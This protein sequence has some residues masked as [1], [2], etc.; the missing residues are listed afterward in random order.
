MSIL[1]NLLPTLRRDRGDGGGRGYGG[2]GDGGRGDF[3]GGR[4]DFGDFGDFGDYGG[5][6]LRG[7]RRWNR[8]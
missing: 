3:R 5:R 7:S 4:D 2:R 6:G 8:C 1:A